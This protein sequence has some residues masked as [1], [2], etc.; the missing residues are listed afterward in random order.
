M[1]HC[2]HL[3]LLGWAA[4]CSVLLTISSV[5]GATYTVKNHAELVTAFAA[6]VDKDS[7]EISAD[8]KWVAV[9]F[10]ALHLHAWLLLHA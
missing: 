5:L 4:L 9:S 8:F 6:L 3:L 2:G 7:I 10:R 1:R